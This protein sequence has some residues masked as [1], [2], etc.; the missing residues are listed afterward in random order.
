MELK[1]FFL[2]D[3]GISAW[4]YQRWNLPWNFEVLVLNSGYA[5][6]SNLSYLDLVNL[7]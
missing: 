4:R 7:H 2:C 6:A 5:P 1:F 3:I